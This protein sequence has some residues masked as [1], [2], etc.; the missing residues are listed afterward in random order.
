MKSFKLDKKRKIIEVDGQK[1]NYEVKR[2]KVKKGRLQISS[3]K[4]KLTIIFPKGCKEDEGDI[5]TR[6]IDWISEHYK[7]IYSIVE[8][9]LKNKFFT[10]GRLDQLEVKGNLVNLNG[11]LWDKEEFLFSTRSLLKYEINKIIE[12]YSKIMKIKGIKVDVSL[13]KMK[14]DSFSSGNTII[15]NLKLVSLP[16]GLIEYIV[17]RKLLELLEKKKGKDFVKTIRKEFKDVESREKDF[18]NYWSLLAENK[19]WKKLGY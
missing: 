13:E 12:R 10:F 6:Y 2:K 1:I 5:I 8:K 17:Y 19:I 3:K 16:K 4:L 11:L 7:H 14:E 15:F 9:N 18:E